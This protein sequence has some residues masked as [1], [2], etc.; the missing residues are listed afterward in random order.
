[1]IVP[2]HGDDASHADRG[3]ADPCQRYQT[4]G[5]LRGV[6][7]DRTVLRGRGGE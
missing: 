2:A 7:A 4:A 5:E 1:M 3:I 6:R